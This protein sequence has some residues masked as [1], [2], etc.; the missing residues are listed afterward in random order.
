[1][2]LCACPHHPQPPSPEHGDHAGR[3]TGLLLPDSWPWLTRL[4]ACWNVLV[5]SYLP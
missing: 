4:L 5:W 3:G 2:S 1:M